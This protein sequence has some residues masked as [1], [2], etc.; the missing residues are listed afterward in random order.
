MAFALLQPPPHFVPGKNPSFE[1]DQ[2]KKS[3]HYYEAATE[4]TEKPDSVRKALLLHVLGPAGR[5]YV[6][7]FPTQPATAK[8]SVKYIF[9]N[10][11]TKYKPYRNVTQSTAIF[12]TMVQKPGQSIDD[13]ATELLHQAER[14]D[15]GDK[16][17]RLVGDRIIVG[18][19]DPALKERLFRESTTSLDK[20]IAT[21]NAA[22]ISKQQVSSLIDSSLETTV[23]AL[24]LRHHQRPRGRRSKSQKRQPTSVPSQ[25]R[26]QAC[27]RCG[28]YHA[29]RNC[30]A[31]GSTCHFCGKFGHY[32]SVCHQRKR[33]S[34]SNNDGK[35]RTLET[36]N[37]DGLLDLSTLTVDSVDISSNWH[38]TVL[39]CGH[40]VTFKLDTGSDVNILPKSLIHQWI[41]QLQ[42]KP[43][44][45]SVS[46]YTGENLRVEN[47][48]LLTCSVNGCARDIKF[49]IVDINAK[50]IL[51]ATACA[52]LNLVCRVM[53]LDNDRALSSASREYSSYEDVLLDFPDVFEGV[54]RLPGVNKITLRSD[55]K[56]SIVAPRKVPAA[57]ES[58]VKEELARMEAN[59]IITKV[60]EPTDWVHPIVIVTKKNGSLRICLDPRML[61]EAI[62]REHY[63]IP[64]QDELFSR[65]S[66]SKIFTVFD[67]KSA[68]WQLQLDEP[69]SFLCQWI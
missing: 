17:D 1:W 12:N 42:L 6:D 60:T 40:P 37:Y 18:L 8:D 11:D 35:I 61:N 43:T 16:K 44:S 33:G 21:C 34:N 65:L 52:Q 14:C 56:P 4:Y 48:C 19:R 51:G 63:H 45:L 15:F 2:W 7:T 66:G 9:D 62:N 31:Y 50:P 69:S 38:E 59:G 64:T 41:H 47:E 25:P 68:F 32:A 53:Q 58:K 57:I 27:S 55:A 54:G 39:V 22:E 3:Y 49:L 13:F 46:T 20:I 26:R 5:S 36:S 30:P 23:D 24:R 10:F 29:P 67:A 28:T